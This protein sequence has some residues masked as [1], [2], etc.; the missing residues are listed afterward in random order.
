[1]DTKYNIVQIENINDYNIVSKTTTHTYT[2]C[3]LKCDHYNNCSLVSIQDNEAGSLTCNLLAEKVRTLNL[4]NPDK[5][6]DEKNVLTV[7]MV[8]FLLPFFPYF[9]LTSCED[10]TATVHT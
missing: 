7:K 8:M 3:I 9:L 6:S 10:F 4:S 1:M 5:A 2:E